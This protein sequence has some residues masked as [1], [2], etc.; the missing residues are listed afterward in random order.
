MTSLF[1]GDDPAGALRAGLLLL[2]VLGVA[3]TAVSLAYER[4][5]TTAWQ[6]APWITLGI[7]TVAT[8]ALIVRP[9]GVTVWLARAAAV[10]AIV[11]S[12]LGVW[13]HIH[14]NLDPA[15]A[16]GDHT[17]AP[18]PSAEDAEE[19]VSEDHHGNDDEA[20]TSSDH[21]A[22]DD[23]TASS[24]HH[25][26]DDATASSDHHADDEATPPPANEP[27]ADE[28]AESSETSMADVLTGSA[29]SVPVPAA[30]AI[31]PVGLALAL[32]TIGLGGRRSAPSP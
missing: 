18:A 24:D 21:H 10:L 30:L 6:W 12:L 22:D 9:T 14:V 29:G 7:I 13:Q 17:H 15:H 26:D 4:H 16:A 23:A 5:W 28:G 19:A 31:A 2:V 11:S 32:A 25:A 1:R 8:A 27:A 3:G 20:A